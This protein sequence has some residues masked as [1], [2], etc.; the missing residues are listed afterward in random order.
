MVVPPRD[1]DS[2]AEAVIRVLT[3][4][5]LSERLRQNGPPTATPWTYERMGRIFVESIES[6]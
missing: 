5:A 4:N 1:P 2:L 6:T 3:D